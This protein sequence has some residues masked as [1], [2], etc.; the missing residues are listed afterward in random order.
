MHCRPPPPVVSGVE[1]LRRNRCVLDQGARSDDGRPPPPPPGAGVPK[2]TGYEQRAEQQHHHLHAAA[3]GRRAE[4]SPPSAQPCAL[5]CHAF[6]RAG[7]QAGSFLRQGGG[8]WWCA[9]LESIAATHRSRQQ[10]LPCRPGNAEQQAAG[11]L[12]HHRSAPH[13]FSTGCGPGWAGRGG[14]ITARPQ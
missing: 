3:S 12:L 4:S 2:P 10:R 13:S 1:H 11:G 5:H 7:R 8:A 6:T 9:S 14:V